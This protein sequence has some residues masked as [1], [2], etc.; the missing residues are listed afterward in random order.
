MNKEK[1][2]LV[3][4]EFRKKLK[5]TQKELAFKSGVSQALISEIERPN[6]NSNYGLTLSSL[7]RI[8]T[9]LGVTTQNIL[10]MSEGYYDEIG[11]EDILDELRANKKLMDTF[12]PP[13]YIYSSGSVINCSC[14]LE[15]V[16]YLPLI[17]ICNLYEGLRRLD[18]DIFNRETYLTDLINS[19]VRVIPDSLAKSY[20]DR[21]YSFIQIKREGK[22]L[23]D[24][25]EYIEY[26][27]KKNDVDSIEYQEEIAYQEVLDLKNR[28]CHDYV[29][30][31]M[32]MESLH[33][34]NQVFYGHG[35]DDAMPKGRKN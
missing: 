34:I 32:L 4:R 23:E 20:A 13:N 28:I 10:D 1:I 14:L 11:E 30:H 19:A 22:Q 12:Y 16:I 8:A 21:I 31:L 17:D 33:E 15:F 25:K 2:G 24:E 35:E 29:G 26:L 7:D 5:L 9:A 3:I 6:A 18:G 27:E